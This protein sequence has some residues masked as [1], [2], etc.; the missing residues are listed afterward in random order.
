MYSARLFCTVL[1]FYSR[2]HT[3]RLPTAVRDPI[4]LSQRIG[5]P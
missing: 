1:S 4:R 5:D 3:Q 2:I